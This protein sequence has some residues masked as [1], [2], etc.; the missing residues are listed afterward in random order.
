[1]SVPVSVSADPQRSPSAATSAPERPRTAGSD[2]AALN[3]RITEAGL[4]ERLPAYYAVRISVVAAMFVAAWAVVPLLG[5]SWWQLAVAALLGVVFAQVALLAHDVAHRQVFRTRRTSELVGRTVANAGIGMSY[6][7]WVEKHTRHHNNPNHDEL[8]PDVQPELLIWATESA[9]GRRGLKG[10]IN[11]H[12]AGLFFPLLTLLS[13]DLRIS[14]IKALRRPG[15]KHRGL[16]AG[17]MALH[18]V[19]YAAVLL[20]V[21]SPAQALAF[22][23]VHHAVFGVY[24][25]MT[26]APNHK[27]MPHPTGDEDYLRK[28]VLTA[29][30]VTGGWLTDTALGGLN[31]QIEH[32]L[33]PGM[34]APNLRKARPIVKAYC[35]QMGIAYE[36][37]SL[38]ESYRQALRHLH[39]VGAPLRASRT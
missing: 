22:F 24:L 33:F 16:E 38:V 39:D 12:Q 1:M 27:G 29:R 6:G 4:L 21:L 8:D 5:S 17:L 25:G 7:W 15:M 31:H 32:H 23:V 10:F 14:S 28:Q 19:A 2:F 9:V 34:P 37:T 3:R 11:R 36:E 13:I 26:F 35:A 30:N 18:L 20:V